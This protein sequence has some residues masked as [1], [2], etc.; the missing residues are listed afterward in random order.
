MYA[1][2][3]VYGLVIFLVHLAA[4]MAGYWVLHMLMKRRPN[5]PRPNY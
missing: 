3:Q 5:K 2:M 4:A 1:A